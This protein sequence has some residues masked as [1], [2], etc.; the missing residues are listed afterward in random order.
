MV[1][2]ITLV[3]LVVILCIISLRVL[4]HDKQGNVS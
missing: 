1:L 4:K 2:S 3:A